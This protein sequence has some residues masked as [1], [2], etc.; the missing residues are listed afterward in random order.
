[1]R[2]LAAQPPTMV[3]RQIAHDAEQIRDR[4][5]Q[6]ATTVF[7]VFTDAVDADIS[8]LHDVF[9]Q[10]LVADD[11]ARIP[12]QFALMRNEQAKDVVIAGAH[13]PACRGEPWSARLLLRIV[14]I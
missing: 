3:D 10:A 1:M 9:S 14:R 6:P 5:I 2:I 4:A 8:V 12:H 13:S 7:C 11:G